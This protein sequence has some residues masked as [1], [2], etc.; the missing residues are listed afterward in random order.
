MTTRLTADQIG[1]MKFAIGGTGAIAVGLA[2]WFLN[3]LRP[4]LDEELCIVDQAPLGH[5]VLVADISETEDAITLPGLI[6]DAARDLPQY[7]RLSVYRIADLT[8]TPTNEELAQG[9]WPLVRVFS[10]CNPGRGDE[11]NWLVVG[12][13]YAEKRYQQMF[14]APLD[15]VIR[16]TAERAG[17]QTSPV[18][19]ALSQVPHVQHFGATVSARSLLVRSDFLQ[20]TPPRYTQ[21]APDIRDLDYAL[22]RIGVGVPDFG[23]ISVRIDFVRRVKAKDRQTSAHRD[24]WAEYFAR[25]NVPEPFGHSD[26]TDARLAVA[27]P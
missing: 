11:V 27:A 14:A 26:N 9:L 21:Y 24:F 16:E 18:L 25:A 5:S 4:V 2:V 8:E 20:H 15:I 22:E 1:Y 17:S 23:G 7:H 13:R 10:A 3:S 6:R 12:A 19:S